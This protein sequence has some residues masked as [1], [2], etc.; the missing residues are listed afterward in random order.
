[1]TDNGKEWKWIAARFTGE[2]DR[3]SERLLQDWINASSYNARIY[4]EAV[5]IWRVSRLGYQSEVPDPQ[6]E[7]ER[8][9]ERVANEKRR[10]A[11]VHLFTPLRMAA[12]LFIIAISG[13]LLYRYTLTKA[14]DQITI[15]AVDEVRTIYLPDSSKVWLNLSSEI[16]YG[17]DFSSSKRE[18]DLKGQAYFTVKSDSL[19]PFTI[20]SGNTSIN[21]LGT[22]FDVKGTDSLVQVIV[23][24]GKVKLSQND[25]NESIQLVHGQKGIAANQSL[26]AQKNTNSSFAGWRKEN[27]PNYTNEIAHPV[28]F[29]KTTFNYKKN[30]RNQTIINGSVKNIATLAAYENIKIKITYLRP[31]GT[32]AT[33][34]ILLNEIANPGKRVFFNSSLKDYFTKN[35]EIQVE[36]ENVAVIK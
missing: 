7:W 27:N 3:E 22:S 28:S 20:Q 29:L 24:E 32:I 9:I 33:S 14:T 35:Q 13:I 26:T 8:L 2:I 15:S 18:I 31:N 30:D 11:W 19:H 34:S 10:F 6:A 12:T 5:K 23:E 36:V 25:L 16:T 17:E 4:D 21:V 1:M